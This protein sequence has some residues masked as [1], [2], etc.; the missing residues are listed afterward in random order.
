MARIV[1]FSSIREELGS[2]QLDMDI[3]D[4]IRLS[5]VI[6]TLAQGRGGTWRS[7]LMAENVRIAV[8]Q[9]MVNVDLQVSNGDEIAFF[10]PVTGG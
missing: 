2:E 7:V 4:G 1:F 10:P 8:N 6:E 3:T 9:E 5:Q